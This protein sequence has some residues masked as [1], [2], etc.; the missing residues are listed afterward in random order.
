MFFYSCLGTEEIS[1]SGT[2]YL[3]RSEA[4][5]CE[6]IVTQFLRCG[7]TP[8]QIGIITP[9][10]GQR[11]YLVSYLARNGAMSSALYAEIEVENFFYWFFCSKK[12]L[13]C[14]CRFFSRKRKGSDHCHL[15][16]QQ[17]A[18]GRWVLERPSSSEC[19]VDASQI[20]SGF[21]G[22]PK[23]SHK[24]AVVVCLADPLQAKRGVG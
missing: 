3:N 15:R 11:S 17:R 23:S 20:R 22:K 14:K 10:E 6:K 13:D 8:N 1:G 18:S 4:A 19:G 9:Y 21:A 5:Q 24:A 7:I 2:S 12:K 16:S